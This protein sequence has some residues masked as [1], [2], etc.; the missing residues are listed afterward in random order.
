MVI[1][2][3]FKQKIGDFIQLNSKNL[4]GKY[5]IVGLV[6]SLDDEKSSTYS[7]LISKATLKSLN[8]YNEKGYRA[9]VHFKNDTHLNK[10]TMSTQCKE[11]SEKLNLSMPSMNTNYFKFYEN[12]LFI[13]FPFHNINTCISRGICSNTE[14]FP[15]IYQ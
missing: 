3:Q 11:I 15:Y 14:Y 6:D 10:D 4:K 7:F 5:K 13:L 2:I 12:K 1:K 8:G 9:Y